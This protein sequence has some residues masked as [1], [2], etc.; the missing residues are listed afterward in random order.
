VTPADG[1]SIVRLD[2][3]NALARLDAW[4]VPASQL[5]GDDDFGASP[6][7]FSANIGG[8]QTRMVGAC[9]KNGVFY[10]LRADNL[11]LGP[12]WTFKVAAPSTA[13]SQ[14][15]LGAAVWDG[16]NLYIAGGATTIKGTIFAGSVR[17]LD[18]SAGTAKWELGL[19]SVVLGSMALDGAG[20]LAAATYGKNVIDGVYLIDASAG[21]VIK[22]MGTGKQFSQP[23]FADIFLLLAS[24]NNLTAYGP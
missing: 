24:R 22:F 19:N 3:A 16:T 14:A 7:I 5:S 18:P 12:V 1:Q 8:V 9:N 13:G 11:A 15:C 10:A 23:V 4:R 17:Q 2:G 20:V 6:T 21:S